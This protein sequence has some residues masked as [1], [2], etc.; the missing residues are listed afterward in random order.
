MNSPWT[1][2]GLNP[3]LHRDW[4]VIKCPTLA[5]PV[6]DN[7][8]ACGFIISVYVMNLYFICFCFFFGDLHAEY[9]MLIDIFTLGSMFCSLHANVVHMQAH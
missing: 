8:G 5:W 3:G 9:E 2:L 4:S 1:G 6:P 7:R